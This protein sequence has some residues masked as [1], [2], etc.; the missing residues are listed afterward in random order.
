MVKQFT[1]HLNNKPNA[2]IINVS[3]GLAF[4]TFRI[5]PVYS[6]TKAGVCAFTRTLRVQLK[7]TQIRIFEL[8][9]PSTQTPLQN[10]FSASD[11][12]ASSNMDVTF[13]ICRND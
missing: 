12:K 6:A 13:L 8:V 5:S 7:N 9:P 11:V 10:A 4:V 1:A 3:S 2:A